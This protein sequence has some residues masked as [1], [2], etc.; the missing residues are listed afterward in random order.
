MKSFKQLLESLNQKSKL[1]KLP[2]EP[3]TVSIPDDHIRLYHQTSEQ[4][5]DKIKK[6]GIKFSY[7]R[8]YEGPTG[9][10]SST[11]SIDKDGD[12]RGFYGKVKDTPTVE[13]HVPKEEYEKQHT[14]GILHRD[15]KP[16]EI[17]ACHHPWH[18]HARYMLNDDDV[19]D[20]ILGGE[21]DDYIK[22]YPED[23]EHKAMKYIKKLQKK[24]F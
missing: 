4:N 1:E 7:A 16:E 15:V 17:I 3:G 2:D 6:D 24:E 13:F 10:Y 5:L 20:N 23:D 11:G 12:I 18:D 14:Y 9:I 8:G 19:K 21:Y 22:K